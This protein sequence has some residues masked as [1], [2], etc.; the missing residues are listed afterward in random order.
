MPE[1]WLN[2]GATEV[3]LEIMAENLEETINSG[4][5]GSDNS[6]VSKVGSLGEESVMPPD[7]AGDDGNGGDD[8]DDD[9]NN[10]S[11]GG[12]GDGDSTDHGDGD[13]GSDHGT[14]TESAADNNVGTDALSDNDTD[15]R[16][17]AGG[18]S[19]DGIDDSA[20]DG[21]AGGKAY[22]GVSVADTTVATSMA[23]ARDHISAP[24]QLE[25]G[26]ISD[27]LRDIDV[28]RPFDL[29]LLHDSQAV[30]QV[31]SSVFMMCEQRAA[32]FPGILADRDILPAI[33]PGLP[34]GSV[35]AEFSAD[36]IGGGHGHAGR[37]G[38]NG[39]SGSDNNAGD[40]AGLDAAGKNRNL[41][42]VAEAEFDGLFGYET[43]STR[44]LRR[45][46]SDG[47]LAAYAKRD[48]N[49]PSPGRRTGSFAE[50]VKFADRFE[51]GGIDIVASSGGISDIFTGHP[52][53]TAA[54][55]S[56]SLESGFM[57]DVERQRTLIASTGKASSNA[58]LGDALSSVWNCHQAVRDR[59]LL[60]LV[61]ECA[62]GLG[63][64]AIRMRVE[65][66]LQPEELPNPSTYVDGMEELLFLRE[67]QKR[68][69]V[70]LVSVLP[71]M[72]TKRL[73]LVS[74]GGMQESVTY[75]KKTQGARQKASVVMDGSRLLLR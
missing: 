69:Q 16:A 64:D 9:D 43:V 15:G 66:V 24:R 70:A 23:R 74:L 50:A 48:G 56:A 12:D 59:G 75:L 67:V 32:Q 40:A 21:D 22:D 2:Y 57:L 19:I 71:E 49:M 17:G 35:A 37:G 73:G 62:R 7:S 54:K 68:C 51:I 14:P 34:E 18:S 3:V 58:T 60:V 41:I 45:F 65:G 53:E 31:V 29:V 25:P 55:A 8:Y 27:I 26:E 6:M 11:N 72:Y 4:G 52:S 5:S 47:M 42:F 30:R 10:D 20:S 39:D 33:K 44:L 28:A 61:A 36:V 1:I 13:V 38:G 46:G 63:P